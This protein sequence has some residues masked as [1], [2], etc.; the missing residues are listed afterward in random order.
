MDQYDKQSPSLGYLPGI[1]PWYQCEELK[2][3]GLELVNE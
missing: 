3:Q 1:L 2:K